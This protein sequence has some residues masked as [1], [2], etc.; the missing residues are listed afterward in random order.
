[1]ARMGQCFSTSLDAVGIDVNEGTS[2]GMDVDIKTPE[3]GY[4]FSDGV[5]KISE[6]LAR[7]VRI[8]THDISNLFYSQ[9]RSS[10]A[11]RRFDKFF[12][13]LM[14]SGLKRANQIFRTSVNT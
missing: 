11:T 9:T 4:C 14:G 10:V 6:S 1:M 12:I 5:G 13:S 2:W 7:Q 8:Q 3:G